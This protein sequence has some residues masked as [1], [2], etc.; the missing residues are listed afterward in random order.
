MPHS[1]LAFARA[2]GG[3][4]NLGLLPDL[5]SASAFVLPTPTHAAGVTTICY[6]VCTHLH[7]THVV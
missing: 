3:S 7:S 5:A 1:E 6:F 2:R 4:W